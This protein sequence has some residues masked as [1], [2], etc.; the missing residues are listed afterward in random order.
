M[1]RVGQHLLARTLERHPAPPPPQ[2]A[3]ALVERVDDA[4]RF[5][6]GHVVRA[7]VVLGD[8]DDPGR[9]VRQALRAVGG[10]VM[11]RRNRPQ[12]V[13]VGHTEG[14]GR[15]GLFV[16][17]DHLER[18]RRF[19][20]GKGG[21]E[22]LPHIEERVRRRP[23]GRDQQCQRDQHDSRATEHGG[24]PELAHGRSCSVSCRATRRRSFAALPW[25]RVRSDYSFNRRA[26]AA[27]SRS[28]RWRRTSIITPSANTGTGG[29]RMA[30]V[31]MVL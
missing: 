11:M 30:N 16:E 22:G 28:R 18:G 5:V 29:N 19:R 27:P 10:I 15:R 24:L 3:D 9:G 2:G 23:P 8:R 7:E 13:P 31:L 4:E 25:Q 1:I 21:E 12:T 14:R 20:V 6:V 17:L 26:A